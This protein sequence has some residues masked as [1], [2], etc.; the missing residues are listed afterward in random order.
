MPLDS[1]CRMKK[2]SAAQQSIKTKHMNHSLHLLT[3]VLYIAALMAPATAAAQD[4]TFFALAA[5]AALLHDGDTVLIGNAGH[6][7]LLAVNEEKRRRTAATATFDGGRAV[8]DAQAQRMVLSKRAGGWMLK[9]DDTHCLAATASSTQELKTVA[10]T[11]R[12]HHTLCS[13]AIDPGTGNADIIFSGSRAHNTVLRFSESS[14]GFFQCYASTS[15]VLPVQIYRRTRAVAHMDL[16]A[17]APT[18]EQA[19]ANASLLAKADGGTASGI[20]LRR[21]LAAD[22]GW[23]TMCLP[24]ALLPDDIE[25]VL[26]GATVERLSAVR[27]GADGTPVMCFARTNHMEAGRPF[28]IKMRESVAEPVFGARQIEAATVPVAM[29]LPGDAAGGKCEVVFCGT[30]APTHIMGTAHRFMDSSGTH[31][32]VPRGDGELP[33]FRAYFTLSGDD[34]LQSAAIEHLQGQATGTPRLLD[35]TAHGRAAQETADTAPCDPGGRL[36][37]AATALPGTR[38]IVTRGKKVATKTGQTGRE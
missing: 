13:I 34:I 5:D 36:L 33:P 2:S 28:I 9:T 17:E 1:R 38:L 11:D 29:T 10:A 12:T 25:T 3:T 19:E 6:G 14:G 16:Y 26:R 22:G 23:Y 18:Q 21:T 4:D 24:F 7:A 37:P 20:T 27:R 8:P 32:A 35:G 15:S 30:F 31:L